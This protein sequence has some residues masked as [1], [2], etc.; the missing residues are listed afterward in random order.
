MLYEHVTTRR[1][2]D[3]FSIVLV[4]LFSS[5]VEIIPPRRS[6]E[7]RRHAYKSD[8]KYKNV[9]C[10]DFRLYKKKKT[11]GYEIA[12]SCRR[13]RSE[14]RISEEQ[15]H[16][17]CLN[18]ARWSRRDI[19]QKLCPHTRRV[20]RRSILT[21]T[22]YTRIRT[23]SMLR[24]FGIILDKILLYTRCDVTVEW[25]NPRTAHVINSSLQMCVYPHDTLSIQ[26]YNIYI[27]TTRGDDDNK[28]LP[29]IKCVDGAI[30]V[31]ACTY[32]RVRAAAVALKRIYI[33]RA[34]T[35]FVTRYIRYNSTRIYIYI[36]YVYLLYCYVLLIHAA[37]RMTSARHAISAENR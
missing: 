26:K 17:Q 33:D 7:I 32:T 10:A 27:I 20:F 12:V 1:A 4:L 36:I 5:L 8:R 29:T 22:R 11:S 35:G 21:S 9:I 34:R 16:G 25:R 31:H 14:N 24:S 13:K 23:N 3:R 18:D 6:D 15:K 19:R 30:F 28:N 37:R 2:A